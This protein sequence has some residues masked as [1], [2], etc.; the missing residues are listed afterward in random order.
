M[1]QGA[2]KILLSKPKHAYTQKL[3]GAQPSGTAVATKGDAGLLLEA[4][5]VVVRF[6]G[7]KGFFGQVT[8]W[9]DAV[10]G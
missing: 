3:L 4:Q 8:D 5:D 1:E 9:V 6:P 2:A 10:R 7:G